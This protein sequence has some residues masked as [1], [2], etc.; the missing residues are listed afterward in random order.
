MPRQLCT[1]V[2]G[3][4]TQQDVRCDAGSWWSKRS[5]VLVCC[6][7]RGRIRRMHGKQGLFLHWYKAKMT[8]LQILN[9]LFA[10]ILIMIVAVIASASYR[11]AR[12]EWVQR[13]TVDDGRGVRE[14]G[15]ERLLSAAVARSWYQI[16]SQL[17]IQQ[18]QATRF[19]S[20]NWILFLSGSHTHYSLFTGAS[21]DLLLIRGY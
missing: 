1:I 19:A 2:T 9:S 13:A 5:K 21:A 12:W 20:C 14:R 6:F 18:P 3:G 4:Q 8:Q 11:D 15:E 16:F 17:H 10:C 7:R